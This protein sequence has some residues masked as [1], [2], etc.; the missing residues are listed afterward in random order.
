[1]Q[2]AALL[3]VV[4]VL[5]SP[6]S[7]SLYQVEDVALKSDLQAVVLSV[8]DDVYSIVGPLFDQRI[9]CAK[10]SGGALDPY[11]EYFALI[12]DGDV[13]IGEVGEPGNFN[14]EVT[15]LPPFAESFKLEYLELVR[16]EPDGAI[17]LAMQFTEE[18][19]RTAGLY[20]VDTEYRF[21]GLALSSLSDAPDTLISSVLELRQDQAAWHVV[22]AG[23][24]HSQLRTV[25][26]LNG[27]S[28]PFISEMDINNV[29]LHV[30]RIW[31]LPLTGG[32]LMARNGALSAVPQDVMYI[33]QKVTCGQANS[34]TVVTEDPGY[35]FDIALTVHDGTICAQ[36]FSGGR[37]LDHFTTDA[38]AAKGPLAARVVQEDGI[39]Y[40][41]LANALGE[42]GKRLV[43]GGIDVPGEG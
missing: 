4:M 21:S 43:W 29:F 7:Q 35:N 12:C 27:E 42:V 19:V 18:G 10:S 34:T 17:F 16:P 23:E 20:H 24:I 6:V 30:D 5:I 8:D 2:F 3:T 25:R 36:V 26:Y 40:L 37:Y 22:T 9:N 38:I 13:L 14:F 41:Y 28:E 31:H 39:Y 33:E 15:T 11:G 1:M 32:W